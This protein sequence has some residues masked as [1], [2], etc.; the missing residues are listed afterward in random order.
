MTQPVENS[1][2]QLIQFFGSPDHPLSTKE[3][4]DFWASL[5]DE[6]KQYY[7]SQPLVMAADAKA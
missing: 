5:T 7:K 6:E 4:K 1:L 3:F 2:P